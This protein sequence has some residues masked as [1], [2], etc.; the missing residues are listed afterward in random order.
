MLIK[1][2]YPY[3]IRRQPIKAS[4]LVVFSLLLVY[5]YIIADPI[6]SPFEV[7]FPGL[8]DVDLGDLLVILI[9]APVI[10]E[11]SFRI[12][13]SGERKHARGVLL[14]LFVFFWFL[15]IWW[16]GGSYSIIRGICFYSV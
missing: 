6:V 11:I 15:K 2:V 13:L 14:M 5:V 12:H 9:A 8:T 16:G 7:Y 4:E 10:E 3:N 1:E